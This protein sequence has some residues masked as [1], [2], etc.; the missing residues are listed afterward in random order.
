MKMLL[1][2]AVRHCRQISWAIQPLCLQLAKHF[3]LLLPKY[4]NCFVLSSAIIVLPSHIFC[5]DTIRV[6][7]GF[8]SAKIGGNLSLREMS[9]KTSLVYPVGNWKKSAS[10]DITLHAQKVTVLHFNILNRTN[11]DQSFTICLNNPHIPEATLYRY[12]NG[13]LDSI[14]STGS[15]VAKSQR[16]S[17]DR[18]LSFPFRLPLGKPIG[19]YIYLRTAAEKIRFSP[20]LVLTGTKKQSGWSDYLLGALIGTLLLSL[21]AAVVTTIYLPVAE[22]WCF[23][24]AITFGLLYYVAISGLGSLYIWSRYS[25]FQNHGTAICQAAATAALLEFIR[26]IT[27]SSRLYPKLNKM[28]VI[29]VLAY[30]VVVLAGLWIVKNTGFAAYRLTMTVLSVVLMLFFTVITEICLYNALVRKEKEFLWLAAIPVSLLVVYTVNILLTWHYLSYDVTTDTMFLLAFWI[31][32]V[33]LMPAF[34][35]VHLSKFI[36]RRNADLGGL[37]IR[38]SNRVVLGQKSMDGRIRDRVANPDK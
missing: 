37:R 17:V 16:S 6:T 34:M 1:S 25:T 27:R 23:V 24:A 4:F 19:Y 38:Q 20:E 12:E 31:I 33:V 35:S 15:V 10:N 36:R 18:T 21:I 29:S 5:Q 7:D 30:L 22:S 32:L 26:R 2:T 14:G 28:L 9:G 13:R 8:T 11:A 3:N